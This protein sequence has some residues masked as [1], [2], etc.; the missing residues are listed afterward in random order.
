MTTPTRR[1]DHDMVPVPASQSGRMASASFRMMILLLIQYVL[2]AAYNLYGTAPTAAKKVEPFSSP[3]LAA[4]VIVGTLLIAG[5]IYALV[6]SVRAKARLA[7][8]MSSAGLLS[9]LAAWG[10]GSAFTENGDSGFSMAM[11]ATTALALLCYLVNVWVF[12]AGS[13]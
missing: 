13:E 11:A 7:A 8:T 4:H 5:A 10:A 9:L 1:P 2:G 3:L 6:I 12:R